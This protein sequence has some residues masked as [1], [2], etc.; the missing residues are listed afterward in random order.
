MHLF[1]FDVLHLKTRF[2]K[3]E[4]EK[5]LIYLIIEVMPEEC[6]F[7]MKKINNKY[8][9]NNN[10]NNQIYSLNYKFDSSSPAGKLSGTALD[11]IKKYNELAKEAMSNSDYVMAEVYRQYAEHYRKI[12]TDI[13]EKKAQQ[14]IQQPR[15]NE[16]VNPDF[17]K[18]AESTT[19][20][21]AAE[22]DNQ[23]QQNQP[24]QSV[25]ETPVSQEP[26]VKKKAFT[27]IEI[28]D[29]EEQTV[30][31]PKVAKKRVYRRKNTA[32]S[33][34]VPTTEPSSAAPIK[35]EDNSLAQGE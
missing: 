15:E 6:G 18:E 14:R 23:T 26:K 24:A 33:E 2:P 29:H 22:N 11:L 1:L 25:E 10:Y 7:T 19:T 30:A 27:V 21:V 13:N 17:A 8:R 12:V 3:I 20:E 28:S 35:A 31:A 16:N 9:N 34:N 4:K 32:L 5:G